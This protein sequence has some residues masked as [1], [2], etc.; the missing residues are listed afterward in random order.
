MLTWQ[1]IDSY[2]I[3]LYSVGVSIAEYAWIVPDIFKEVIINKTARNDS[4]E[5]VK[6]SLRVSSTFLIIVFLIVLFLGKL[7]LQILFGTEYVDAY[8]VT[9][10]IFTGIYAMTY[11]KIIGT[12][13]IAKGKQKFYCNTLL[14]GTIANVIINYLVI[15][16]WNIYGAAIAT[17]ISYTIVGGVFIF[18]FKRLY[19]NKLRDIL[20]MR[21][22]DFSIIIKRI[23][24]LLNKK[25][26]NNV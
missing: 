9:V 18:E 22:E 2:L 6:F 7:I 25:T 15:P 10:I 16:K 4:I 11:C 19:N 23:K 8:Y 5:D 1:N 14:A 17:V 13:F 24:S 21:K 3:G 20:C 26:E 12:L